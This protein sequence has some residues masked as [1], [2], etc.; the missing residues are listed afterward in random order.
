MDYFP[1]IPWVLGLTLYFA[2]FLGQLSAS[3]RADAQ[4][5]RFLLPKPLTSALG[6]LTP[7]GL[8]WVMPGFAPLLIVAAL[9]SAV[10]LVVVYVISGTLEQNVDGIKVQVP[11]HSRL[12]KAVQGVA[13]LLMVAVM[14]QFFL[15]YGALPQLG[16]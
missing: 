15:D 1:L 14:V 5:G 11:A 9:V 8:A 12:W 3:P 2:A 16:R 7:L 10:A 6:I 13:S 4:N